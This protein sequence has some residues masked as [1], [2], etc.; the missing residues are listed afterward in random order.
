[1]RKGYAFVGV[2]AQNTG[3]QFL[4]T[5]NPARYSTLDVKSTT[6]TARNP[7]TDS[8]RMTSSPRW[9]RR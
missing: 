5:W 3:A 2:T 9:R 7:A 1:M 4:R 8:C 6:G